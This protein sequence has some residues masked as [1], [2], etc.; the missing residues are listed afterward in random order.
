MV[1]VNLPPHLTIFRSAKGL[2]YHQISILSKVG[3]NLDY[4]PPWY[5]HYYNADNN[6]V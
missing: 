4:N 1:N 6:A 2:Y 3:S 5:N